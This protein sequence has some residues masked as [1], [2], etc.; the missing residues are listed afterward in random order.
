MLSDEQKELIDMFGGPDLQYQCMIC[1]AP[2]LYPNNHV[3]CISEGYTEA[4]I[5][6]VCWNFENM[7]EYNLEEFDQIIEP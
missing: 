6:D 2:D 1:S 7:D 4:V 5:C 3:Q